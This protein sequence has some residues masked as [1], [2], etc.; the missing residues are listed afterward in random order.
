MSYTL[1]QKTTPI[2][3]SNTIKNKIFKY[4]RKND[5]YSIIYNKFKDTLHIFADDKVTRFN[6]KKCKNYI[7]NSE[8]Y[9]KGA[10]NDIEI[11]T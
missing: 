2:K 7:R 9:F 10:E 6:I 5:D 11:L 1:I 4:A 8:Y 3:S